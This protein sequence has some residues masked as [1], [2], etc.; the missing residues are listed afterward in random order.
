MQAIKEQHGIS[1]E[2]L[3]K[4]IDE[5]ETHSENIQ[6]IETNIDSIRKEVITPIRQELDQNKNLVPGRSVVFM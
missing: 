6:K 5:L 3:D 4:A 2:P 1:I